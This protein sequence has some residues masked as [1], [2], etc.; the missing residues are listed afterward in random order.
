MVQNST[1]YK[2]ILELNETFDW[3]LVLLHTTPPMLGEFFML[4]WRK[5]GG[6]NEEH[7]TS[8]H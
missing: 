7:S 5:C 2:V 8:V 3:E 6:L 4:A 1:F